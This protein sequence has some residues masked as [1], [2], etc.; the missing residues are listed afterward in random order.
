MRRRLRQISEASPRCAVGEPDGRPDEIECGPLPASLAPSQVRF[1][2]AATL[3]APAPCGSHFQLYVSSSGAAPFTR[4]GDAVSTGS[5]AVT[6]L[7]ALSP[8]AIQ[9]IPSAGHTLSAVPPVWSAAPVRVSYLWQRCAKQACSAIRGATKLRLRLTALDRGHAVRLVATA[10]LDG[11][12][13]VSR[14]GKLFV[15]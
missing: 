3:V 5:C 7:H 1:G 13:A 8:P 12:T 6:R 10:A 11:A 14:S 15:R 2:F 9:G 4:A